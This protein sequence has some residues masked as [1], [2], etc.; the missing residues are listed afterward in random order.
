VHDILV[1]REYPMLRR[2]SA[3]LCIEKRTS[4]RLCWRARKFIAA[5]G[6]ATLRPSYW[7]TGD[8][9]IYAVD[10][11]WLLGWTLA[12]P[13]RTRFSSPQ[14][15]PALFIRPMR[16]T[17]GRA[18]PFLFR[19]DDPP[20]MRTG[21]KRQHGGNRDEHAASAR[22]ARALLPPLWFRLAN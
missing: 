11:Q 17:R 13:H 19:C 12:E 14:Q 7:T 10:A 6:E 15:K 4:F 9:R 5:G 22:P 16:F 2:S 18:G 1:S 3:R 21:Q 20:D 8:P